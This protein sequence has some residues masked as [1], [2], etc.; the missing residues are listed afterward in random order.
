MRASWGRMRRN[1][2]LERVVSDFSQGAGELQSGGAGADDD[3]VEA[4]R[5]L[6][7]HGFARARRVQKA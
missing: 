3:E 2:V 5:V 7:L 1:V 4:K 6:R